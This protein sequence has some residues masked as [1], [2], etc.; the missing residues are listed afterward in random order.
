MSD[1]FVEGFGDYFDAFCA[2]R[3]FCRQAQILSTNV[4]K[5]SLT[6][7]GHAIGANLQPDLIQPYHLPNLSDAPRWDCSFLWLGVSCKMPDI[8]IFYFG[9]LWQTFPEGT[10]APS[11]AGTFSLPRPRF[12]AVWQALKTRDDRDLLKKESEPNEMTIWERIQPDEL[13]NKEDL[14]GI[15]EE[16]LKKIA[17]EW[18]RLWESAGGIDRIMQ[19]PQPLP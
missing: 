8:G 7:L 3:E 5:D 16:K 6:D 10:T 13:T 19:T 15:V 9:L 18:T 1:L 4:L 14:K 2:V 11:A 17:E 12:D